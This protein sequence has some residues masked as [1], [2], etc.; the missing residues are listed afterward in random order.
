MMTIARASVLFLFGVVLSTGVA[1]AQETPKAAVFGG[2]NQSYFVSSPKIDTS[3]GQGYVFGGFV[4]LLR[5][6]YFKIQPEVQVSQRKATATYAGQD[7]TYTNTYFNMGLMFRSK[8]YKGLYSTS[9]VQF[10]LPLSADFAVPGGS[11]DNKENIAN[12]ISLVL[13]FG[14]QF[15]RIGIEGRWDSG[16]KGI[17]EIPLG[18]SVKRNR[19]FTF[20]GIVG[21]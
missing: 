19:A 15:G 5:D 16:L 10:S 17:E 6:K 14:Q 11:A 20:I 4:V 1:F 13:G 7:T 21:F 3:A 9:G 2:F 8:I 12:D 18:G